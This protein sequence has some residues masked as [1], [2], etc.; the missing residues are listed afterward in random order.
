MADT[1]EEIINND[2]KGKEN[3]Q[4]ASEE[5]KGEGLREPQ[6]E[7]KPVEKTNEELSKEQHLANLNKAIAEAQ[8][9]LHNVRKGKKV[10]KT[11]TPS[12]E[13]DEL[14]SIDDSDPSA[15][16][17]T[18]RINDTVTPV[19]QEMEKEKEEIRSFALR[20]FLEDKPSLARNP[21]KVK[22][23]V[24]YY[25]RIRTATER[26][27][28]GVL[29]DLRKAYAVVYSDS[30]LQADTTR[31]RDEAQALSSF[32]ESA[33]DS[34]ATSYLERKSPSKVKL[35]EE[36]RQILSRWGQS[37]DE[38]VKDYEKYGGQNK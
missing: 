21:E 2:A 37:P 23:L 36:D 17:W 12:D 22:E 16:A 9:E 38:W 4:P 31:R 18:K 5:A 27:T 26:T 1:H 3:P 13:E 33:V 30:I 8:T 10:V 32:S 34:G 6:P 20:S 7:A 15:R 25:D 11:S 28:E 35:T 19:Q 24:Q 29:L 14:P